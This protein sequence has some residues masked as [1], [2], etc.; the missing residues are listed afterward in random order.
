MK[1]H[2][3]NKAP[4]TVNVEAHHRHLHRQ[5]DSLERDN[6]QSLNDVEGLISIALAA[7]EQNDNEG[8]T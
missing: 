8:K 7:Q 5:L 1:K 2:E 6:H 4:T 3:R